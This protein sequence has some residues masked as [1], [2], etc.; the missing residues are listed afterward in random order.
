[1]TKPPYWDLTNCRRSRGHPALTIDQLEKVTGLHRD[2]QPKVIIS[3]SVEASSPTVPSA[4]NKE[5]ANCSVAEKYREMPDS[6]VSA[7][8]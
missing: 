3:E 2:K 1:M 7:Y 4:H 6:A 5:H 8:L